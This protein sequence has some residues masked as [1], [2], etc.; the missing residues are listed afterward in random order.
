MPCDRTARC[1]VCGQQFKSVSGRRSHQTQVGHHPAYKKPWDNPIHTDNPQPTAPT[2]SV[3][4]PE[5]RKLAKKARRKAEYQA[6]LEVIKKIVLNTI[7]ERGAESVIGAWAG[8][9]STTH[10]GQDNSPDK[11]VATVMPSPAEVDKIMMEFIDQLLREEGEGGSEDE[12]S[13]SES[14]SES[15]GLGVGEAA[16]GEVGGGEYAEGN[17]FSALAQ[18]YA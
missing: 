1:P 16:E 11:S 12:E 13:E 15:S 9:A 14:G 5:E 8:S 7:E 17:C 6:R 4:T 2:T 10:E 3:S 18:P